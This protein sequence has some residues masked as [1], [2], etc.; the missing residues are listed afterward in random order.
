MTLC[1]TAVLAA[2]HSDKSLHVP[3]L[4]FSPSSQPV[5]EAREVV[6]DA[7]YFLS[8]WSTYQLDASCG[9]PLR[10]LSFAYEGQGRWRR[11]VDIAET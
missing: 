10:G 2:I 6:Y 9:R 5:A 4:V 8:T 1:L 7:R 11:F 3:I